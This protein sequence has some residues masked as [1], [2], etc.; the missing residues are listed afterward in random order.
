MNE[1]IAQKAAKWWADHLRQPVTVLDNGDNSETGAMTFVM[2]MI[3]QGVEKGKQDPATIDKFEQELAKKIQTLTGKWITV[4]TDYGPDKILSDA[5]ECAGLRLGMTTLPWKTIMWIEGD[6][7]LV[8][9]G[10]GANQIE[11]E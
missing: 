4:A 2:A 3:L 5:A 7:I 11:L 8:A 6:R 10:Y 9:E 1:A